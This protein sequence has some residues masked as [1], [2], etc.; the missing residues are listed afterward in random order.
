MLLI[1]PETSKIVDCNRSASSFYGYSYLE[2]L[3][4]KITDINSLPEPQVVKEM[5]LAK[6]E[7]SN[8]FYFKHRLFNGQIRD[9]E[10]NSTPI[11]SEGRNLLSSIIW[12]ITNCNINSNKLK[13]EK[14]NLEKV[15][16]ERTYQLEEANE[17][18]LELNSNL[19]NEVLER[20]KQLEETNDIM[21]KQKEQLEAILEDMSDAVLVFD[22]DDNFTII[23]KTARNT[24][25]TFIGQFAHPKKLGDVCKQAEYFD[26]HDS[27]IPFEDFPGQRI[28]RGEKIAGERLKIKVGEIVAYIE[29][30]GTPLFDNQ[31]YFI[32]GLLCYRDITEKVLMQKALEDSE[33]RYKGLVNNMPLG[34][35]L[36][37]VIMDDYGKPIDYSL[38]ELNP[39]FERI[40]GYKRDEIL[41]K[42]VTEIIPGIGNSEV[43]R[44]GL[45]GEIALTG[46]SVSRE[47]HSENSNKWYE[48][49]YYCPQPGCVASIFSD[50]TIRKN[51]E[52]ELRILKEQLQE[53]QEFAH[54]GYWEFDNISGDYPWSDELF[55]M[56]ASS[57]RNLY[58]LLMIS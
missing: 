7:E 37:K 45:F 49:Y 41:E 54:L 46:K 1:D 58:Q 44:I 52:K 27:L 19:E 15:V 18:L 25:D 6:V 56:L 43:S 28:K 23:N 4:L 9:V 53:A 47:V 32:N 22:K 34:W 17:T 21:L 31:G 11:I 50:I 10:V 14:C 13:V 30:N 38:I 57:R 42:K 40:K 24:L 55:S 36:N 35:A 2:M 51:Q 48:T 8:H 33:A 16:A 12:D 3:K 5:T 39:I 20:T 29:V 26:F